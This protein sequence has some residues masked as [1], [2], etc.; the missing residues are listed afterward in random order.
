MSRTVKWAAAG[1]AALTFVRLWV[2][3]VTPLAPDEAYYWVWS[4]AL[5]AGYLDHPPMVAF[6]IRAG[7]ELAGSNALGVRLFGPLSAA[8][9]S[10]FLYDGA[11]RLFPGRG[12]GL[13]AAALLN[14]TL[15]LGVGAVIMTPDTPSLLF[16][17]ATL[18]AGGRLASGGSPA[19]WLS[20]GVFTGLALL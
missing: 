2:A 9:G 19:W 20:A 14:A 5:A 15:V 16:W 13:T 12:A 6:W 1:L 8:L 3:A 18:W 10:W 4:R 17:T 11:E 7:T